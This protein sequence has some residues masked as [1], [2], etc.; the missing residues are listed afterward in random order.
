MWSEFSCVL[1][2]FN[3]FFNR[4]HVPLRRHYST[5]RSEPFSMNLPDVVL[6][7]RQIITIWNYDYIIDIEFHQTGVIKSQVSCNWCRERITHSQLEKEINKRHHS[8]SQCSL[9][10]LVSWVWHIDKANMTVESKLITSDFLWVGKGRLDNHH[11]V[12]NL[13]HLQHSSSRFWVAFSQPNC[14]TAGCFCNHH[15]IS[16]VSGYRYI[17]P[18]IYKLRLAVC[19]MMI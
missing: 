1:E 14:V 5:Y 2:I 4:N 6:V 16:L 13:S 15:W 3:L 17:P 8:S 12:A 9:A 18:D 10:R 11:N 7:V 19:Q